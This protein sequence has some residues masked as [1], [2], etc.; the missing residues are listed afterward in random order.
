MASKPAE[1]TQ[2]QGEQT[3]HILGNKKSNPMTATEKKVATW[4]RQKMSE[5]SAGEELNVL[6]ATRFNQNVANEYGSRIASLRSEHEGISG[7]AYVDATAYMTNGTDGCD[8]GALVHRANQIPTLL[9][10]SKCGSCVFNSGGSCQK[11][12]KPIIASADEIVESPQ[13]YQQEMIRLANASDS[14]QTAS[15]FVNNYDANEFN[16]TASDEVSIDDA[17]SNEQLGNVLFGGF[18]L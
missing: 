16:L 2:Y 3:A 8:K 13:S 5:G 10:T 4:I 6:I 9:K 15:L 18:E 17:P 7:H 14:E 11:Y 1:A 12:N